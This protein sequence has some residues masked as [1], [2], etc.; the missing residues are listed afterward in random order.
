[1]TSTVFGAAFDATDAERVARFWA[2]ALGRE[3]ADGATTEH[4]VVLPGKDPAAGPRL[5]F[6]QVPE[7]KTAK[8][9]FHLDLITTGYEAELERL[10][11]LGATALNTIDNGARWTTMADPEG[12]EFDLISG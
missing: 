2:A 8:N 1:M 5:A 7:S 6:H 11:S 4:A 9:R 3:V 10:L 12:N